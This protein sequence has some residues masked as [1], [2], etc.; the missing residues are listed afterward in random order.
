MNNQKYIVTKIDDKEV[1]FTF[2]KCVDHDRMWEAM[3]V[4]RFGDRNWERKL[5]GEKVISAGFVTD[6]VCHG[7]SETL[8]I[9]SRGAADTALLKG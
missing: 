6:G 1:I 5:H 7:R 2:P 4:I 8:N 3:H 9:K